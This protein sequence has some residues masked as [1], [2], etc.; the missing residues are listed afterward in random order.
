MEKYCMK[1]GSDDLVDKVQKMIQNCTDSYEL[2]TEEWLICRKDVVGKLLYYSK[3][4]YSTCQRDQEYSYDCNEPVWC[5][6]NINDC[7]EPLW[8]MQIRQKVEDFC[9]ST[10]ITNDTNTTIVCDRRWV[11]ESKDIR[12]YFSCDTDC[13]EEYPEEE[14][15]CKS[16][17]NLPN[18]ICT[19]MH[20]FI[21]ADTNNDGIHTVE[22]CIDLVSTKLADSFSV[23]TRN[24][25][26]PEDFEDWNVSETCNYMDYNNE[27]ILR[28]NSFFYYGR[29]FNK[30]SHSDWGYNNR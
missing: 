26:A 19:F 17:C 5:A 11:A 29:N 1:T 30:V 8:C 18:N 4:Y 14:S 2:D 25:F 23:I 24:Q 22:E 13:L 12:D 27:G 6:E 16:S 28:P 21:L 7:T 15:D 3:K 20:L 9:P 10:I